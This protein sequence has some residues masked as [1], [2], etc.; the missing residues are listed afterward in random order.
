MSDPSPS[1]DPLLKSLQ[2]AQ[3]RISE[4]EALQRDH[5]Q[6]L[7]E[8]RDQACL[9][10]SMLRTLPLD[11]WV[12]DR[13][14]RCVVQSD[15]SKQVWGDRTGN[16]LEAEPLDP[17]TMSQWRAVSEKVMRKE[18]V[19]REVQQVMPSGE[20]RDFVKIAAPIVEEDEVVAFLGIDLDVTDRKRAESLIRAQRDLAMALNATADLDEALGKSIDAVVRVSGLECGAIYL[21]NEDASLDLAF[22]RG[23]SQEALNDVALFEAC[24]PQARDVAAGQ[25]LY[26]HRDR[27][28][29]DRVEACR[30]EGLRA[31]AILPVYHERRPVACV[32]AAS[33][34]SDVV[35]DT[36][37][38]ALEALSA[39][40]GAAIARIR[41][42]QTSRASEE[43]LR[44]RSEIIA[45][46][47][48]GV[49]LVRAVDATIVFTNRKFDELFGYGP[50][51]LLGRNVAVLN[52][53]SPPRSPED[54]G[55]EI[56]ASVNRQGVWEGEILNV[57]KDGATFWCRASVSTFHSSRYG[58]VWIGV[59]GDI[60]RRKEVEEALQREQKKLRRLLDLHERDRKLIAYEIHDGLTQ[61]VVGAKLL[62][63]AFRQLHPGKNDGQ[64]RSYD[65]AVE[66][67][68][69]SIEDARTLINGVRPPVLDEF[70]LV[71]AIEHLV[72]DF[73]RTGCPGIGFFH[74]VEFDRLASPLECSIFRIIQ[75]SLTN[76]CRYSK[77][78]RIE[79]RLAQ[80]GSRV[81]AEIQDWGI[82]FDPAAVQ[83]DRFGL[84]GIRERAQIFGGEATIESAPGKGTRVAAELPIVEVP[85]E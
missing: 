6:R 67:V 30:R 24:S 28:P 82:G 18:V 3:S 17:E 36:A 12:R 80:Q 62:L 56:I 71:I 40:I 49:V 38:D 27:L 59:H 52:A 42:E 72:H 4:L 43:D 75:E 83:P 76:A 20:R 15:F 60:T 73:Q 48:E 54:I 78:E 2:D 37:R 35:P 23:I 31:I 58:L 9:M 32:T 69:Q 34:T 33:R 79:V 70:G 11:F 39:L 25:P 5:E 53:A 84:D 45:N 21:V 64:W 26:T 13:H 63:E 47:A 29:P 8:L 14:G 68:R 57:R 85:A 74:A 44:L 7:Q 1:N 10:E 77:S 55:N 81:R 50:G 66:L 46:L 41:A 19:R 16:L 65:S 51:E 22:S 61:K